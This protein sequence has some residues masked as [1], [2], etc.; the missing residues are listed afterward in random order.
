MNTF[1]I[2]IGI[3]TILGFIITIRQ[4]CKTQSAVEAA[5][6]ASIETKKRVDASFLL[7]DITS[8][9]HYARFVKENALQGSTEVARIKLQD[10]KD[11]ICKFKIPLKDDLRL[12][13]KIIGDVDIC[14]RTLDIVQS[15][16]DALDIHSFCTII[17]SIISGLNEIQNVIKTKAL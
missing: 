8:L 9:I 15:D 5:K 3:V 2:I 12:Y 6:T 4:V 1:N 7:P 17:E 11:G 10:T 14:L 16:K 13:N